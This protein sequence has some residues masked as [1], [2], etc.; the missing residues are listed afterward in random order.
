MCP[1]APQ[2][3][4]PLTLAGMSVTLDILNG[5]KAI[6]TGAFPGKQVEVRRDSAA[7]PAYWA[8]LKLPCFVLTCPGEQGCSSSPV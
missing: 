7:N 6:V 5:M 3:T 8:D 2:A 1:G 4:D